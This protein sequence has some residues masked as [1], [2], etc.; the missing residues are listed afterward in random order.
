MLTK[1]KM[2]CG[3]AIPQSFPSGEVDLSL[4]SDAVKQAEALGYESC[5]V[6]ERVVGGLPTLDPIPLLS[7]A[8][9]FS[10]RVRLGTSVML[11]ALR[12][13]INLAKALATLDQL[14]KGRLIVGVGLGGN[15]GLFPAFGLSSKAR[16]SR[17]EEG[18]QVMKTL[19]TEDEVT[20]QSRF[21]QMDRVTLN[22]KPYQKPYPPIWFG[23]HARDA[24]RR[25]VRLGD[26]WMGAGNSSTAEF[27]EEIKQLRQILEEEG[28]DPATF[29]LSK[30]V[31]VAV[32]K[33]K[34][35]AAR[36]FQ[37]WYGRHYGNPARGLEVPVFGTE[38]ECVE[39]LSE[40]ISQ[41]IDLLMLNPIH[42]HLEQAERLA[43]DVI[44][45]L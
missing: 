29:A 30:R 35:V 6:Q 33:D 21:W 32:E 22:T 36:M 14:C 15:P 9:A 5:W 38:E 4:I 11:T 1:G 10:T 41:D 24:L 31:Y 16:S 3:I 34:S 40:V 42:N 28:R 23:G 25:A 44:P 7:Y 8:S 18:L 45:K 12:N 39:G 43:K 20:L 17:F 2:E 26:G 37:D 13:P 27:K 19:W